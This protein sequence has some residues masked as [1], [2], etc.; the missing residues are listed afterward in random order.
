VN[1]GEQRE[2]DRVIGP[3]L[4]GFDG[5]WHASLPLMYYS[6]GCQVGAQDNE[7]SALL[8]SVFCGGKLAATLIILCHVPEMRRGSD[9]TWEFYITSLLDRGYLTFIEENRK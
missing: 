7:I 3:V 8:C 6:W 4:E 5:R 9:S 2:A 1:I